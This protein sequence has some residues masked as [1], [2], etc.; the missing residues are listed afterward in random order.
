MIICTAAGTSVRAGS[1]ERVGFGSGFGV[2]SSSK[3]EGVEDGSGDDGGEEDGGREDDSGGGVMVERVA[4]DGVK[5]RVG[6]D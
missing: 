4:A 3:E 6:P 5:E 2:V 1:G